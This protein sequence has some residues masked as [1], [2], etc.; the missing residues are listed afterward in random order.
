M[1][2]AARIGQRFNNCQ[3]VQP[4]VYATCETEQS[5]DEELLVPLE[6][7]KAKSALTE[8]GM[9]YVCQNALSPIIQARS[10]SFLSACHC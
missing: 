9:P 8:S 3:R 1:M 6:K 4:G 2:R 7:K 5:R 10:P